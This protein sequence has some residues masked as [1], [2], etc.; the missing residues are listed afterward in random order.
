MNKVVKIIATTVLTTLVG[1][2]VVAI[3]SGIKNKI[4]EDDFKGYT[5]ISPSYVVG[6]IDENGKGAESD[7]CMYS[8]DSIK[9]TEVKVVM[10][11]ENNIYYQLYYYN[12][13]GDLISASD[14][15][16]STKV[17]TLPEGATHFRIM[18]KP[19]WESIEDNDQKIGLFEKYKFYS[20]LTLGIKNVNTNETLDE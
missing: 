18:I 17:Y 8:K 3:V 16:Y 12:E 15:S 10:D 4:K 7:S 19:D 14:V 20:Q 2:A 11:F 1:L 9:A 6:M 13:T 5:K